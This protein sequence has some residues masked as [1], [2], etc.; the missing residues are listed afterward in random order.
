MSSF[1]KIIKN[2]KYMFM[3]NNP[4][5]SERGIVDIVSEY[6]C[7]ISAQRIYKLVKKHFQKD[8]TIT[9]NL[10]NYFHR[11]LSSGTRMGD[12]ID[13]N[14]KVKELNGILNNTLSL[15]YRMSYKN[16]SQDG[17][18]GRIRNFVNEINEISNSNYLITFYL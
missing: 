15:M 5:F 10:T 8:D 13:I 7:G 3:Y 4:I 2:V 14:I 11:I 12:T 17:L 6:C 16:K 1:Y 9:E 18:I